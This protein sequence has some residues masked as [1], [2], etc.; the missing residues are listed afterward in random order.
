MALPGGR[1]EPE[2]PSLLHTARRE[3]RE[4][5][6]LALD[7]E[8]ELLGRLHVV[9]PRGPH[10]PPLTIL[11]FVF[12]V[13]W[14]ARARPASLEV[15]DVFWTRV[16]HLLNPGSRT[17]HHREIEGTTVVFPAFEVEGHTVWGLTY[18][19]LEDFLSRLD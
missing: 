16:D 10:L 11:P 19:I 3:T 1:R 14:E 7:Q 15:A 2:D 6:A 4:E 9:A 12:S 5:V 18:R 17:R 8:G 13:P